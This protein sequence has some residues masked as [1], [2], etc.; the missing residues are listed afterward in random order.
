MWFAAITPAIVPKL[1]VRTPEPVT[2]ASVVSGREP[3]GDVDRVRVGALDLQIP[4]SAKQNF[5]RIDIQIHVTFD[6]SDPTETADDR[7]NRDPKRR[8]DRARLPGRGEAIP[9]FAVTIRRFD[10]ADAL[11]ASQDPVPDA[12]RAFDSVLNPSAF[13]FAKNGKEARAAKEN[14][15][16]N[17]EEN[18]RRDPPI[19]I[20]DV[21]AGNPTATPLF[22]RGAEVTER[23]RNR[24]L[25]LT[26]HNEASQAK[27]STL[28][29]IVIDPEPMTVALIQVPTFV[30]D[31]E[32]QIET[33]GEVANWETSEIEGSRWEIARIADGFDLFFPPQATGE[34]AEKGSPWPPISDSDNPKTIDYRLGSLA[35]LHLRSSYFKQR[36][37]EAPWNLR[38]VLGYAGQRAP[39]AGLKTARFE[40][41]YGL[42]ARF[43]PASVRLAEAGS[44]IG[45]I[46][47]PLPARPLGIG[48]SPDLPAQRSIEAELYDGF[49]ARSAS[50]SKVY[51]TRL[52][53]FEAY[54]EGKDE[55]PLSLEDKVAFAL[56]LKKN[57]EAVGDSWADLHEAP[58]DP[59]ETNGFRGGAT[60]GFE[61]KN[62]YE[63]VIRQPESNLGQ[64]LNPSFSALGGSGFIRA[65]FADGKSRI[66]SDTLQLTAAQSDSAASLQSSFDDPSELLFFTS[67]RA[68]DKGDPNIWPPR[69]NVDFLNVP[70]P[71]PVGEATIDPNDPDGAAPDD[72]MSEP[73][74]G[75]LTFKLDAKGQACVLTR[76]TIF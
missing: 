20:V 66:V 4:K 6:T 16:R 39:G 7:R 46:R 74:T 67:T 49:R 37:A 2:T 8:L 48:R 26:L 72:A 58:W 64:I 21:K 69:I 36:Y 15:E 65:F 35:R 62:I 40:F 25:N 42:G 75:S 47:D 9:R 23:N 14:R 70:A 12:A 33:D 29:T 55:E 76:R 1:I 43:T 73:L 50:Y 34:A 60:W 30:L 27:P 31:E 63:E 41:L 13:D 28:R 38:R 19:V 52:G 32:T 45:A 53:L 18:L 68:E 56:R 51:G 3:T 59:N 5:G 24:R 10:L 61:S 22:L 54:L 44:R 71:S 57:P 11:P 17:I